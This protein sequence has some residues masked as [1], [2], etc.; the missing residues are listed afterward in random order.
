MA[1][2]NTEIWKR[3][4]H[5]HK[6]LVLIDDVDIDKIFILKKILFRKKGFKVFVNYKDNEKVKT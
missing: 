5:C 2:G 3:K 6:I 4:F 1:F